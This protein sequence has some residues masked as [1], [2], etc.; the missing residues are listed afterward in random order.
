MEVVKNYTAETLA[1][2]WGVCSGT[3]RNLIRARKL[4]AFKVGRQIRIR[5]EAVEE[6]E[7]GREVEVPENSPR[8]TLGPI[9]LP[10][11]K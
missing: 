5:P 2:R 10:L 6:Y 9:I 11:P 3:V 7:K 4:K 8:P 1:E